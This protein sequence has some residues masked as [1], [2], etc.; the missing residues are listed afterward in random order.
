MYAVDILSMKMSEIPLENQGKN[1]FSQNSWKG[2][3]VLTNREREH[4]TGASIE[5]QDPEVIIG[6]KA[7]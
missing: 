7:G 1:E 2:R 6:L 3:P 5:R 4:S